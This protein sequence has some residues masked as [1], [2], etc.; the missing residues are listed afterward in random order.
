MLVERT[1]PVDPSL[2]ALEKLNTTNTQ[3]YS[4]MGCLVSKNPQPWTRLFDFNAKYASPILNSD[5]YW[6][7][8]FNLDGQN[9]VGF[10]I[11]NTNANYLIG[12]SR[13]T[14]A[15]TSSPRLCYQSSCLL[16]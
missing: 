4:I 2:P 8:T 1:G 16:S 12:V 11:R 13:G 3:D 7:G 10:E 5:V 15:M 9:K 14:K 6:E